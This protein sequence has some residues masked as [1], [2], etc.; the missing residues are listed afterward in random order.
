M[1]GDSNSILLSAVGP[2]ALVRAILE[3]PRELLDRKPGLSNQRPK[4][5]F[6]KFFVV[7]NREAS[8]RRIGTSQ[9]DV[10][11][12]LLIELI[13]GPSECLD[14]IVAGNNR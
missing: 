8:M 12:V 1:P 7:W 13:S 10:A 4:S 9:N 3:Q 6:S 14:C 11:P 2:A 5:P